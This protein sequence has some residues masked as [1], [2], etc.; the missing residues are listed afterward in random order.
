SISCLSTIPCPVGPSWSQNPYAIVT[1]LTDNYQIAVDSVGNFYVVLNAGGQVLQFT[2]ASKSSSSVIAGGLTTPLYALFLDQSDLLYFSV[3][4]SNQ[5]YSYF[6]GVNIVV[7]G[8]GTAGTG[9]NQ[10]HGPQGFFVDCSGNLYISDSGNNRVQRYSSSNPTS[11]CTVAGD[12]YS[13]SGNS[14]SNFNIPID[15]KFDASGNMIVLDSFNYRMLSFASGSRTGTLT[16]GDGTAG[17]SSG[18]AAGTTYAQMIQSQTIYIDGCANVYVADS[19][20]EGVV[21]YTSSSTAGTVIVTGASSAAPQADGLTFDPL[22]NLYVSER[23]TGINKFA[24]IP[25]CDPGSSGVLAV[26]SCLSSSCITASSYTAVGTVTSTSVIPYGI[27]IDSSENVYV[28]DGSTNS[29]IKFVS[30]TPT[31]VASGT[32]PLGVFVDSSNNIYMSH[33]LTTIEKWLPADPPSGGTIVAGNNGQG[34]AQN[35]LNAPVNFF[36]DCSGNL[37]I[38]DSSNSRVQRWTPGASSGCTMA[39]E[40]NGV[41]GSASYLLSLSLDVKFTQSGNMFVIDQLN[42]RIQKFL[43]GFTYGVTVAESL[44]LPYALAVDNCENIYVS[45]QT[46][47]VYKFTSGSTTGT[48]II[49]VTGGSRGIALNPVNGNLYVIFKSDGLVHKYTV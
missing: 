11:G 1:G 33:S 24:M 32:T 29:I 3:A 37:F 5:V 27:A 15:T 6:D 31:T 28:T 25:Y 17:T 38:A 45:D 23:N 41:N 8:D 30:G 10:L 12:A 49:S 20:G 18:Q 4:G 9:E 40:R 7:A 48:L 21:K 16:A 35:Q 46:N 34:N 26:T 2:P 44:P 47:G 39:G 43:P 14:L 13:N 22:G 36:V 19:G 42:H